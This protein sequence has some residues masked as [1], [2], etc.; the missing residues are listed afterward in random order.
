MGNNTE[1]LA[2]YGAAIEKKPDYQQ[3]YN[4]QGLILYGLQR[5]QEAVVKY[6]KAI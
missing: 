2:V 6:Q 4:A 1:A 3:S 5:Y